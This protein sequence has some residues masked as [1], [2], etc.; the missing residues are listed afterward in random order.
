M[1]TQV[2]RSDAVGR[3]SR[4]Y[5]HLDEF[6]K[7]FFNVDDWGLRR[8][9]QRLKRFCVLA[10][11]LPAPSCQQCLVMLLRQTLR[12]SSRSSSSTL[13]EPPRRVETP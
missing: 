5:G 7:H 12:G 11:A 8:R 4:E 3:A 10:G 13:K 6:L 9:R 1:V 2:K